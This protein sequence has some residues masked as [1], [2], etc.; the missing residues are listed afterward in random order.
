MRRIPSFLTAAAL[1]ASGLAILGATQAPPASAAASVKVSL[2]G[3][4]PVAAFENSSNAARARLL[5]YEMAIDGASCRGDVRSFC[6]V[7]PP[8]PPANGQPSSAYDVIQAN[9]GQ[10][11]DVVVLMTGYSDTVFSPDS[12]APNVTPFEQDFDAVLNLLKA[13][14]SVQRIVMLNLRVDDARIPN[15]AGNNQRNK[16]IAINNALAQPKYTNDPKLRILNWRDASAGFNC[17]G[18]GD[19]N[20]FQSDGISPKTNGPGA[21]GFADFVKA[22]LD[23]TGIAP[24]DPVEGGGS[25]N[26]CASPT[27]G[28]APWNPSLNNPV[29]P[30]P[31]PQSPEAGKFRALQQPVRLMDTRLNN[32]DTFNLPLG[33]GKLHRVQVTGENLSGSGQR[34]PPSASS[35]SLN[36]TST[37]GCG[38]GFLTVFPCGPT[39]QPNASN[40]N[41]TA[42]STVPNAVT[43][44]VGT[45]GRVCIYAGEF[46]TDVIVDISGFYDGN[47]SA[48][49]LSGHTSVSPTRQVDTRA[50]QPANDAANKGKIFPGGVRQVN[51]KV[52]N[53]GILNTASGAVLNVTAVDPEGAGYMTV[54]PGPCNQTPPNASNL[55]YG[56][57]QNV[58]NYVA[59]RVP[60]DGVVCVF[61]FARSDLIVD[62]VGTFQATGANLKSVQPFRLV[63]SRPGTPAAL[64]NKGK[65]VPGVPLQINVVGTAGLP[66]ATEG[67]ILNVTA[68]DPDIGGFLT[69]YPCGPQPATSNLNYRA[70]ETRPNLVD[71]K[72]TGG[73]VCVV[74][75]RATYVIVDLMGY[76][77]P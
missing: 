11:G 49:D 54:F 35:V 29:A 26:R 72:V 8:N 14:A 31:G 66:G 64:P 22:Q 16:F 36:I 25:P 32:G 24:T 10:L 55:N 67:V 2:I 48:A 30:A 77:Q 70:H 74:S 62:I 69:V 57:G 28:Y 63:D 13:E 44:R 71:S 7:Q 56:P 50:G 33:A 61:S 41:F 6:G 34:V 38:G 18:L 43:V 1:S 12:P 17:D 4:A 65:L 76:Y 21:N 27:G 39:T 9:K 52:N 75:E 3:T 37:A 53:G 68:V 40:L 51:L 5:P 23:A 42:G 45:L 15:V 73:A 20:C 59:T 47:L 46:A 19:D 60:N 58:P